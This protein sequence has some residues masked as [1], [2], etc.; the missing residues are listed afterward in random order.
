VFSL[1]AQPA[2]QTGKLYSAQFASGGVDGVR[3]FTDLNFINTSSESRSVS[4]QLVANDGSFAGAPVE[5]TLAPRQQLRAR[6]EALMG[7]GNPADVPIV[8]GSLIAT[9]SGPGVI[10]DVTFGDALQGKFIASLP[11][12]GRPASELVLSQVAQGGGAGAKPYF[13]GVAMY[14]PN[15]AAV[16]VTL[17][18]FS[19]QG[20]KTGSTSLTLPSG[21]RISRVLPQLVPSLTQQLRGYIRLSS[22]APIVVFELFGTQNLDFLAA[23]PPQPIAN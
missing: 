13:T 12:D 4:L 7:L 21:G 14:N 18:V 17:D 15:A 2:S 3:Y 9:A 19:E 22:S 1:P 6:G 23:V 20:Q 10:G 8:E 16:T 5:L 11:L